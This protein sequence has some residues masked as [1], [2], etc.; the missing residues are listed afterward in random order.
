M[1]TWK[2]WVR[3]SV[4]TGF[5]YYQ[6]ADDTQLYIGA[7]GHLSDAVKFS[8]PMP[9]GCQDLSGKEQ[10]LTKWLW[11]SIGTGDLL[12]LSLDEMP[13]PKTNEWVCNLWVL[14][15]YSWQ[16]WPVDICKS[17]LYPVLS[18]FWIGRYVCSHLCLIHFPV[19]LQHVYKGPLEDHLEDA[20][21]P[22]HIMGS[23]GCTTIHPHNIT[24]TWMH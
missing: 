2:Y 11:L 16:L 6:Y 1:S 12:S 21:S 13:L 5:K 10:S 7:L 24:A 14:V 20:A 19:G 23:F 4:S 15:D 17:I 9:K 8:P 22:E 3:P 18:F